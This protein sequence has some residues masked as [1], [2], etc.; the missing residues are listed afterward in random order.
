MGAQEIYR[1]AQ[2][3]RSMKYIITIALALVAI[4]IEYLYTI[5]DTAC[6][7]LKGD[8]FG[9]EL[10]YIGIGYMVA[11]I[12]LCLLKMDTLLIILLSAGFGIELYLIGFQLWYNTYCPYCLAFGGMLMLQFFVHLNWKRKRLIVAC[13]IFALILFSL[14]FKGTAT[15]V[16]AEESPISTFGKGAIVVRLYTDYFCPPCKKMEPSIEPVITELIKDNTITFTFIDTPFY[17]L[18]SLYARYFLYGLNEK[19][20][21]EHALTIRNVLIEASDQKIDKPEK[22]EAYLNAKG[23]KIKPYDTR[24]TFELFTRF[25][26]DDKINATPSC[27]IEKEGKKETFVGGVEIVKALEKLKK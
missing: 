21:L 14:V 22:L 17:K 10:Q 16:Y 7:Y 15:P 6:S 18:S 5:C 1:I 8:V 19:K 25:L 9:I 27:V 26:K 13:M 2:Y 24:P 11:I 23:I 20:T 12:V 3:I 4:G